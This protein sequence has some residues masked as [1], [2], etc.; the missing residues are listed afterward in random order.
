M[1]G[2]CVSGDCENRCGYGIFKGK[3][4]ELMIRFQAQRKKKT[5]YEWYG[6]HISKVMK[7]NFDGQSMDEH[8]DNLIERCLFGKHFY[9]SFSFAHDPTHGAYGPEKIST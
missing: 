4:N 7:I 6:T 8:I 1:L 5:K 2:K 9:W 3:C